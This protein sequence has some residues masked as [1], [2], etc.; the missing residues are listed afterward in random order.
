MAYNDNH[1]SKIPRSLRE[2]KLKITHDI[3][4]VRVCRKVNVR[5]FGTTPTHLFLGGKAQSS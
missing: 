5:P 3:H 2:N 1:V 4:V